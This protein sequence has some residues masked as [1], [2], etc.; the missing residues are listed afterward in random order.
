MAKLR[1]ENEELRAVKLDTPCPLE[2]SKVRVYSVKA[3]RSSVMKLNFVF[4]LW[5]EC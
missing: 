3:L 1:Y 2:A 4:R 5:Q